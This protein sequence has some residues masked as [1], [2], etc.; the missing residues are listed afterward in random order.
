LP[1]A[2]PKSYVKRYSTVLK[3]SAIV[4]LVLLLLIPLSMVHSVL[5]E[6]LSRRDEAVREITSTWGREQVVM[7]PV[8]IIPFRQEQ[9]NW[10][11]KLVDGKWVRT[12]A[13]SAV[14]RR[15]YFL[16][17]ALKVEGQLDPDRLH[18]GIYETVVYS[19]ILN[20]SGSFSRPSFEEWSP[21][22]RQILWDQAEIAVSITDLRGAQESLQIKVGGQTI[23]SNPDASWRALKG[24][25]MRA[26]RGWTAWR[27]R[28]RSRCL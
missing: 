6:R 5:R 1:S 4:I 8:L 3:M 14:T 7:G 18:R 26:L 9:K 17:A 13:G 12:E 24:A 16:P 23:P 10:E 25:S 22:P 20:L 27:T 21:D 2:L 19:G 28:F 15:A 11:D